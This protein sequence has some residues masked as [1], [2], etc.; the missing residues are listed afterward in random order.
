MLFNCSS[1]LKGLEKCETLLNVLGTLLFDL[2]TW[3][4]LLKGCERVCKGLGTLRGV[5]CLDCKGFFVLDLLNF[6]AVIKP[7]ALL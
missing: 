6:Q 5:L 4:E 3:E 2:Q 7:A 1:F